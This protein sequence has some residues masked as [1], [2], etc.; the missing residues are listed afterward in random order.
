MAGSRELLSG[1]RLVGVSLK[2]AGSNRHGHRSAADYVNGWAEL[3]Q[4]EGWTSADAERLR[5][6]IG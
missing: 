4:P 3:A 5:E 1:G 2:V 6:L